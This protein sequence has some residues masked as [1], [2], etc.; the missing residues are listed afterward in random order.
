MRLMSVSG[1]SG[2]GKTTLI[3]AMAERF[4]GRGQRVAVIVNE[5]GPEIY[6]SRWCDARLVAIEYIRGG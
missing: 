2:S 5:E 3:K 6:E 4:A 1:L